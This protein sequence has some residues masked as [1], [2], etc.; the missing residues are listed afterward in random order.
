MG[1][2]E[3]HVFEFCC[4]Q[5]KQSVSTKQFV[6]MYIHVD[7]K[8]TEKES[9]GC[10]EHKPKYLHSSSSVHAEMHAGFAA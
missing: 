4:N 9:D 10:R 6:D 2:H 8:I 1:E 7:A 5:F 3:Y